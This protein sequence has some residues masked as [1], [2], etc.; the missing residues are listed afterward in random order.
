M[1]RKFQPLSSRLCVDMLQLHSARHEAQQR[2]E[3]LA[4]RIAEQLREL[5]VRRLVVVA[6]SCLP[7]AVALCLGHR[8]RASIEMGVGLACSSLV[9]SKL[10]RP[11]FACRWL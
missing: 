7:A 9:K 3:L 2:L 5:T 10:I 8:L 1:L 4:R 11:F 6:S